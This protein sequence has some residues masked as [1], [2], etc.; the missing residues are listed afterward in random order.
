MGKC[1]ISPIGNVEFPQWE[2]VEFPQWENLNFP[3]GTQE[4]VQLLYMM[5]FVLDF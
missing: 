5:D 3:K 2:N 4:Q 1:G